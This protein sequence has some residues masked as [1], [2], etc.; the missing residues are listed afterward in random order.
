[1]KYTKHYNTSAGDEKGDG[2]RVARENDQMQNQQISNKLS[3][4][5][6]FVCGLQEG[7]AGQMQP[8]AAAARR[9]RPCSGGCPCTWHAWSTQEPRARSPSGSTEVA[10]VC[11]L[12]CAQATQAL[13]ATSPLHCAQPTQAL[14]PTDPCTCTA[15]ARPRSGRCLAVVKKNQSA[16]ASGLRRGLYTTRRTAN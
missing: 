8:N 6:S 16:G 9:S 15:R 7:L 13:Q 12:R 4:P 1:M 2:E 10:P 14:R 3:V 11:H 5:T